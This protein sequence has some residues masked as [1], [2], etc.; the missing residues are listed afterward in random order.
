MTSLKNCIFFGLKS[1]LIKNFKE[2]NFKFNGTS[3]ANSTFPWLT[4]SFTKVAQRTELTSK[5]SWKLSS[6]RLDSKFSQFLPSHFKSF[7]FLL[8]FFEILPQSTQAR[9]KLTLK[10]CRPIA[11]RIC[12]HNFDIFNCTARKRKLEFYLIR[13]KIRR[14]D[15]EKKES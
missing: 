14:L 5:S 15:S 8:K 6:D 13:K 11:L 7:N 9:S 12:G 10:L 4:T 2:R 3:H 1:I